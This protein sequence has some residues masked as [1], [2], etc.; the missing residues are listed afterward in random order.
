MRYRD[1]LV[2]VGVGWRGICTLYENA[3]LPL[4]ALLELWLV[5][6]CVSFSSD[7]FCALGFYFGSPISSNTVVGGGRGC[8]E[9]V[10]DRGIFRC[11][12]TL[13]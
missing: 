13:L 12:G 4:D 7:L 1:E 6:V 2:V 5:G 10:C 3:M 8:A 11:T 9:R